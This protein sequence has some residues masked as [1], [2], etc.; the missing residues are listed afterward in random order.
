[1]LETDV[2][3]GRACGAASTT[4]PRGRGRGRGH[5]KRH[6]K[7]APETTKNNKHDTNRA[8]KTSLNRAD[9]PGGG[10]WRPKGRTGRKS[11]PEGDQKGTKR[12]SLIFHAFR[13][14]PGLPFDVIFNTFSFKNVI[15]KCV[16]SQASVSVFFC[17][18]R[19]GPTLD[20]LAPAQSKRMSAPC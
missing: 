12:S 16:G 1:M 3:F 9:G 18:F 5:P 11:E 14:P 20:P 2:V 19:E 7:R 15:L 10:P 17:D 4:L 6:P 13:Q 8:P